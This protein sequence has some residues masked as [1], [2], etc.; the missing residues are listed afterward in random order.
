MGSISLYTLISRRDLSSSDDSDTEDVDRPSCFRTSNLSSRVVSPA[1][2]ERT[3]SSSS[4]SSDDDLCPSPYSPS[5]PP[6]QSASPI[7]RLR[8]SSPIVRSVSVSSEPRR[9]PM[10]PIHTP[11]SCAEARCAERATLSQPLVHCTG[12]EMSQGALTDHSVS[13]GPGFKVDEQ[14]QEAGVMHVSSVGNRI[15]RRVLL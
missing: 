3:G 12:V 11:L 5:L 8:S 7:P 2:F 14:A 13:S 15:S 6:R 9:R 1:V 4:S 10:S